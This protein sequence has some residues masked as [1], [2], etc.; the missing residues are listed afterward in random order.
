MITGGSGLLALNWAVSCRDDHDIL[1]LTHTKCVTLSGVTSLKVDLE[2]KEELD[3]IIGQWRPDIIVHTAGMTNVDECDEF[4]ERAYYTNVDLVKT[5]SLIAKKYS[6]K[7]VYISSDHIF[8]GNKSFNTENDKTDTLNVYADSKLLGE[9]AA[10]SVNK[11]CLIIRTNFFGWGT[12][13]KPSFSDWVINTIRNREEIKA[14]TDIFYTPIFIYHLVDIAIK[15]IKK[16]CNGVFNIVGDSRISK[17]EFILSLADRFELDTSL[18]KKSIYDSKGSNVKRPLDMSLSNALVKKTLRVDFPD[19]GQ[20]FDE[21][22]LQEE[23][24]IRSE[25]QNCLT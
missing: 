17:Y 14:Y 9:K 4:P 5:M 13:V 19:L 6:I 3:D 16:D 25:I 24:G 1:L 23:S 12:S 2:N 20:S 8:S 22:R 7:F 11:N 21:L 15:L 10:E 18:I